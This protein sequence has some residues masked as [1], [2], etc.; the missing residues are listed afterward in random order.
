VSAL[1]FRTKITAA[2]VVTID[3]LTETLTPLLETGATDSG[4]EFR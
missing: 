4:S 1:P 2:L 3:E